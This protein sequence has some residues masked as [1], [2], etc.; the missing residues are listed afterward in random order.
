MKKAPEKGHLL[1]LFLDRIN[2]I[3]RIVI[4]LFLQERQKDPVHPV[5]PV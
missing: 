3:F 2:R 4:S 1:Y 5:N